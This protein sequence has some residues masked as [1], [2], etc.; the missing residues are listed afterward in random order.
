MGVSHLRMQGFW[1]RVGDTTSEGMVDSLR[2][3]HRGPNDLYEVRIE[4]SLSG[5]AIGAPGLPSSELALDITPT[6]LEAVL[7]GSLLA[8]LTDGAPTLLVDPLVVN[9]NAT[10]A[11]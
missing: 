5:S 4:D 6:V 10:F 2:F 1:L 9:G 11:A 7:Y 3:I 8:S